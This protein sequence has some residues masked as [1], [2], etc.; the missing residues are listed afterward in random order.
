MTVTAS[1]GFLFFFA[2]VAAA[3]F[4]TFTLLLDTQHLRHLGLE[5]RVPAFEVVAHLV[6]LHLLCVEDLAAGAQDPSARPRMAERGSM[7]S[8]T[9]RKEER[10]LHLVRIAQRLRHQAGQ[11]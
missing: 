5:L 2:A 4:S 6:R 7:P 11:G 1:L 10:G 9:E 3:F 8:G